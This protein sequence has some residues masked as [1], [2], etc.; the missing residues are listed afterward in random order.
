MNNNIKVVYEW[1]VDQE[2]IFYIGIGEYAR[3]INMSEGA[4]NDLWWE[5]VDTYRASELLEEIEPGLYKSGRIYLRILHEN[6]SETESRII[7]E[8]LIREY[9]RIGLDEGGILTNRQIGFV[10]GTEK[11]DF[12]CTPIN[13]YQVIDNEDG[14]KTARFIRSYRDPSCLDIPG[15]EPSLLCR[16]ADLD[17]PSTL[18]YTARW[19]E[20]FNEDDIDLGKVHNKGGNSTS[21]RYWKVISTGVIY[22]GQRE[23][24]FALDQLLKSTDYEWYR[25][26]LPGLEGFLRDEDNRN[27]FY[28]LVEES[29]SDTYYSWKKSNKEEYK[30]INKKYKEYKNQFEIWKNQKH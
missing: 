10:S 12:Y 8:R 15:L 16:C 4:R 21:N 30:K 1:S 26:S 5:V 13:I 7:E 11:H 22:R 3:A 23:V 2:D 18:G 27:K 6:L 24:G 19:A 9:G 14:T 28:S 17:Q 29:D 20:D 25:N